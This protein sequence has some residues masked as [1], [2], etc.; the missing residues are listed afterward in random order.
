MSPDMLE[1]AFYL[2]LIILIYLIYRLVKLIQAITQ[3]DPPEGHR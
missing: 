2:L 1:F 3:E